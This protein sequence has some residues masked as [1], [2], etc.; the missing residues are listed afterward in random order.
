MPGGIS[1]LE[2]GWGILDEDPPA[3]TGF[4][5]ENPSLHGISFLEARRSLT[6]V[7]F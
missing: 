5:D 6:G 3:G 1:F 2:V 4:Q 7:L